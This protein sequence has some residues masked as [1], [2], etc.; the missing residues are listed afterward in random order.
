MNSCVARAS[1]YP[2]SPSEPPCRCPWRRGRPSRQEDQDRHPRQRRRPL[3]TGHRSHG[4]AAAEMA[5]EDF[6]TEGRL[7][8][9]VHDHGGKADED[10]KAVEDWLDKENIAVVIDVAGSASAAAVSDL[11]HKRNRALAVIDLAGAALAGRLCAPTTVRWL[12]DPAALAGSLARA[13]VGHG[14]KQWFLIAEDTPLQQALAAETASAVAALGGTVVGHGDEAARRRRPARPVAAG[15]RLRRERGGARRERPG[16]ARRGDAGR[17]ARGAN[18]THAGRAPRR[19]HRG[20]S[21]GPASG[22]GTG[23]RDTLL[24]GPR[25]RDP[26]LRQPLL[27]DG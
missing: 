1:M 4:R 11:L 18:G 9:E 23:G 27:V 7:D 6:A 20:G 24:L 2:A 17:R 19:D 21:D 26:A 8:A 16:S 10:P 5:A 25:R 15:Q 13:I 14:G 22:P 3:R 12:E